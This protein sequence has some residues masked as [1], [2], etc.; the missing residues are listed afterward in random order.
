MQ[1]VT[2]RLQ[3]SAFPE[4][5]LYSETS[6]SETLGT[7]CTTCLFYFASLLSCGWLHLDTDLLIGDAKS[8]RYITG[9]ARE[10]KHLGQALL[11]ILIT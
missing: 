8:H 10:P 4:W 3:N 6:A 9:C 5:I 11:V 2:I 1:L 7:C